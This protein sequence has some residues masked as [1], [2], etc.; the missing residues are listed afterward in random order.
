MVRGKALLL[1]RDGVINEKAPKAQYVNSWSDFKFLS[2]SINAIKKF[3]ANSFE[4]Y[5][6][7]NQAGIHRGK[8]S[9][10]SLDEIHGNLTKKFSEEGIR[11]M[12][13]IFVHMGGMKVAGVGSLNQACFFKHHMI[14]A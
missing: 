3:S 13:Y 8:T 7:T 14:I 12:E 2:G 11:Y 5:I 1:D 9:L 10:S 4:I 6:I